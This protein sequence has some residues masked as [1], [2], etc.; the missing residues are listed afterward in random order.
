M[1]A[2]SACTRLQYLHAVNEPHISKLSLLPQ[3][4]SQM[5]QGSLQPPHLPRNSLLVSTRLQQREATTTRLKAGVNSRNK[6]CSTMAEGAF[7][8]KSPQSFACKNRQE[9]PQRNHGAKYLMKRVCFPA[10]EIKW[11]EIS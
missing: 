10:A 1:H 9:E 11:R 2:A 8:A 3:L 4:M 5:Q 6:T 7:R